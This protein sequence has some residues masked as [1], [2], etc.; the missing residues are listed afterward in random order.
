MAPLG[1]VDDPNQSKPMSD[2]LRLELKALEEDFV[3]QSSRQGEQLDETFLKEACDTVYRI[4]CLLLDAPTDSLIKDDFRRF[5][6]FETL[7]CLVD[8]LSEGSHH[9]SQ[10]QSHAQHELILRLLKSLLDVLAEVLKEHNGNRQYFSSHFENGGWD[11]LEKYLTRFDML[12]N[13]TPYSFQTQKYFFGMLFTFTTTDESLIDMFRGVNG[14]P[15]EHENFASSGSESALASQAGKIMIGET[16]PKVMPADSSVRDLVA[17]E[18]VWHP[19]ML[20]IIFSL[21]EH[22]LP[23]TSGASASTRQVVLAVLI[24][25][26]QIVQSSF[27]NAIRVQST[28]LQSRILA[29]L[30][31]DTMPRE[32]TIALRELLSETLR[33]G[34]DDLSILNR[35]CHSACS[36]DEASALLLQSIRLSQQPSAFHFDLSLHGYASMEFGEVKE[37]FPPHE[38]GYSL[39]MWL[40]VAEFDDSCHSTLFGALTQDQSCFLLLYI[41]LGTRQL[42]LQTSVTGSRP[43]VRFKSMTFAPG[44]WYHIAITHKPSRSKTSSH[45]TLFV[46]GLYCEQLKCYYPGSHVEDLS[47]HPGTTHRKTG[48]QGRNNPTQAFI[49]TPHDL[50]PRLGRG[51]L[52][53]RISI[54]S[55]Y[56]LSMVLPED[57]IYVYKT[58]GPSYVGNFQDCLGSFQTYKGSADLNLRNETRYPPGDESSLITRAV[59]YR[60]GNINPEANVVLGVSPLMAMSKVVQS[61]KALHAIT[62]LWPR[63]SIR[64]LKS[65]LNQASAGIVLN[66]GVPDQSKALQRSYGVGILTGGSIWYANNPVCESIG[67]VSGCVPVAVKLVQ[68]AVSKDGLVRAVTIFFEL[69]RTSWRN[70]ETTEREN[71]FSAIALLLERKMLILTSD[72]SRD[73]SKASTDKQNG[74]LHLTILKLILNFV[75]YDEVSHENTLMLNPLAYSKLVI[76]TTIWRRSDQ[77]T[78]SLYYRQFEVF[79]APD[80][81]HSAFNLKRLKQMRQSL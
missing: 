25:L 34:I 61:N 47:D 78:Q 41:E 51:V 49:G 70:S 39:Q 16:N 40:K 5:Q 65:Y 13:R 10:K 43:S 62:K 3:L 80:T 4:R 81:K 44:I 35:L 33:F 75:G 63:L 6:G 29:V 69:V 67:R 55:L 37:P 52:K 8:V 32:E 46:D 11:S 12:K 59:R 57:L 19:E 66:L 73:K 21:L 17:S 74:S 45:A 2:Q 72:M 42:V 77:E 15:D 68:S 22:L 50:S 48:N 58:L 23:K 28:S 1:T 60:A 79:A 20:Q 27:Y 18:T 9:A 76:E 14:S 30:L 53:S 54:A 36:S 31:R 38:T 64:T 56:L 71:G 7:L 24:A 26:T